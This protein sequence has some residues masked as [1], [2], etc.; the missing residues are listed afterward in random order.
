MVRANALEDNVRFYR[1]VKGRREQLARRESQG[2]PNEWHALGLKADGDQ[3]TVTYDGK[4]LYPRARQDLR[5][6]RK[7]RAV[8][9]GVTASRVSNQIKITALPGGG[10]VQT[11]GGRSNQESPTMDVQ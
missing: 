1:V 6:S 7:H 5:A 11:F 8:D 4:T 3:F 2:P 10:E 9:Q